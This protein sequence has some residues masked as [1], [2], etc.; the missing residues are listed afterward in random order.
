MLSDRSLDALANSID[1]MRAQPD[2]EPRAEALHRDTVYITVV[3]GDGL[4][5]SLIYSTFWPFGS[6]LASKRFR[7]QHCTIAAP[8]FPWKKGTSIR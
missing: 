5:V 1:P 2:R 7:Y 3:D 4:A 8:V 6:G